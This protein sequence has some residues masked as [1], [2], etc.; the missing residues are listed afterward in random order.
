MALDRFEPIYR[1]K[2]NRDIDARPWLRGFYA[3]MLLRMSASD[4]L[5]NTDDINHSLL[6]PIFVHCVDDQVRPLL[7]PSR[8]GPERKAFARNAYTDIPAVVYCVRYR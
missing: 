7:R 1:C 8:K 3:A 2:A 4:R 6:L 5:L